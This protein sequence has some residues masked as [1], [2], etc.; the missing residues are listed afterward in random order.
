MKKIIYLIVSIILLSDINCNATTSA[1]VFTPDAFRKHLEVLTAD[2]L[3]GRE[4]GEVGEWKAARYIAGIFQD[5]GL[6]PKGDNNSF[7]QAFEFIKK[8]DF[9][10]NNRLTVDGIELKF[11][12]DFK[13]LLQSADTAFDFPEVI[14][15][16]FGLTAPDSSYDDYAGIDVSGKAVL[17][18]RF[19]PEKDDLK[20]PDSSGFD[21]E[22]FSSLTD[23][24][25]NA[26]NHKVK[27]IFFYTPEGHDDTLLFLG[28]TRVHQEDIPIIYLRRN[29]ITELGIDLVRPRSFHARGVTELVHIP[30]TGYNVIGYLPG[31]TDTTIIIG[32]HYDHLGWGGPTSRYRGEEKRIHPGADDNASGTAGVLELARYYRLNQAALHH[33]FLFIAF[34]GEEKGILGSSYFSRHMTVDSSKILMMLNMDMIGR[35]REAEKGLGVLGVGTSEEFKKYFDTLSNPPVKLSFKESGTGPSDHTAFY[36]NGIPVLF[37]FTGVHED[38]HKPEDVL[39]KINFDGMV[40]VADMVTTIT[41]HFDRNFNRLTFLKTKSD[42][43][44]GGPQNLSVTLGIMPDFISEVRGLRVDGV[45]G[46]RPAER[47]GILKG[48]VIIR[49][50]D[51]EIYDIYTYM[52]ALKKYRKGDTTTVLVERGADTL[53]LKVEFK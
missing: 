38:Y 26:R 29:A 32:A 46:E 49:I 18:K 51:F 17:I 52:N 37:F 27:G 19:A 42:S 10:P 48:D 39:D 13:P 23:K 35:L 3:E 30:D 28:A 41:D 20:T 50:G 24:I 4:A 34:S 9:S 7:L 6:Q 2:S 40:K 16:N 25:I 14:P 21:F 33:S 22:Q 1:Y 36:N 43:T 47:A 8:I 45:S 44:Y 31:T 15:V 5:V 53:N 12:T 11:D